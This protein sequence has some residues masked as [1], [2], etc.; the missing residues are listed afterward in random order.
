MV[1]TYLKVA[2]ASLGDLSFLMLYFQHLQNQMGA[3]GSGLFII[4]KHHFYSPKWNERALEGRD[5][6]RKAIGI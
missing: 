6:M 2:S 1:L 4:L 3:A 5:F